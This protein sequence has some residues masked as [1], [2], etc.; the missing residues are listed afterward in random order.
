MANRSRSGTVNKTGNQVIE[1][2]S[3]VRTTWYRRYNLIESATRI[4]IQSQYTKED[5]HTSE[6]SPLLARDWVNSC[7]RNSLCRFNSASLARLARISSLRCCIDA[8]MKPECKNEAALLV[9]A[10]TGVLFSRVPRKSV[11]GQADDISSSE[12][13]T[14]RKNSRQELRRPSLTERD[15][16]AREF[17]LLGYPELPVSERS[18]HFPL[19]TV[20]SNCLL[21]GSSHHVCFSGCQRECSPS[22]VRTRVSWWW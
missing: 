2:C 11:A 21:S 9:V 16:Q 3:A 7:W 19:I 8:M 13:P 12:S 6:A 20:S 4:R 10:T 1:F 14:G 22:S 5:F 17:L 18:L 15:R